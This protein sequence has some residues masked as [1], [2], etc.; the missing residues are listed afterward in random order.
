MV[1]KAISAAARAAR[2]ASA[3]ARAASKKAKTGPVYVRVGPD[4]IKTTPSKVDATVDRFKNAKVIDNPNEGQINRAQTVTANLDNFTGASNKRM[5]T[6]DRSRPSVGE[7][8]TSKAR[9]KGQ[10]ILKDVTTGK[11]RRAKTVGNIK[12]IAGVAGGLGVGAAISGSS[13]NEKAQANTIVDLKKDIASMKAALRKART[14]TEKAKLKAQIEKTLRKLSVAEN[15]AKDKGDTKSRTENR[16]TRRGNNEKVPQGTRVPTSKPGVKKS[17]RPKPRP[18]KDG[19]MPM[20][21]KDGKKVPAFAAD[22]VGKM[23]K[24]GMA[25]KKPAKKMMAGGMAKKKP[26]AKKMMAGG[27]AKK[28]M[29]GG[30]M[31]KTGYMY[32]G[33]AKKKAK[34]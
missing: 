11:D 5:V 30:G 13:K 21:M 12:G 7:T 29:M 6:A 28:K 8:V 27:M 20:V 22:G 26:A 10:E 9:S 24:G 14:E 4:V 18:F 23:N 19:G 25:M 3:A 33:M 15:K 1:T 31:A 34:K 2:T 17:L 16:N 32:G